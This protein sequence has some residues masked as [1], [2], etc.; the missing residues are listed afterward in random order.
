MGITT[1]SNPAGI[2]NLPASKL[3]VEIRKPGWR[4]DPSYDPHQ[5]IAAS[6]NH[7]GSVHIFAA[8]PLT[9]IASKN[10]VKTIRLLSILDKNKMI[11]SKY[12]MILDKYKMTLDGYQVIF[13]Q[14]HMT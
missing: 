9:M 12:Q 8:Q 1:Q 11:L 2:Q 13:V 10:H 6:I 14:Y 3:R 5:P 7:N 4:Q